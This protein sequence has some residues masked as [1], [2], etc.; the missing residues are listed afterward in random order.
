MCPKKAITFTHSTCP[1]P[2]PV[3]WVSL[4]VC[5]SINKTKHISVLIFFEKKIF[6]HE[7]SEPPEI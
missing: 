1:R 5:R 4:L 7:S 3:V 2:T 6:Y